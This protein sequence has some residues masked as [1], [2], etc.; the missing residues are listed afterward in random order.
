MFLF[1]NV[2]LFITPFEQDSSSAYDYD[3]IRPPVDIAPL[4]AGTVIRMS[5]K[6]AACRA[7]NLKFSTSVIWTPQ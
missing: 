5:T 7:C 6:E 3:N 2:F 1:N 4:P